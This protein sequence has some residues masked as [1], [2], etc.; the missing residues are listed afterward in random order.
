MEAVLAKKRQKTGPG[1][2]VFKSASDEFGGVVAKSRF[3]RLACRV[4]TQRL[5]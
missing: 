3:S 2:L 4:Q 5:V 1:R